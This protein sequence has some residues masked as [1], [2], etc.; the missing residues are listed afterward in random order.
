MG[1]VH[2]FLVSC[3]TRQGET[4]AVTGNTNVLGNW[5]K[6]GIQFM[7][8]D[9][10]DSNV[11]RLAVT[12]PDDDVPEYRYCVVVV[13]RPLVRG[14]PQHVI[15][16]RWET[17]ILPRRAHSQEGDPALEEFGVVDKVRRI[18]R[19][20]LTEEVVVQ[21]KLTG[22]A[23][24][25]W[26]K[27]Y[28]K[29]RL[30]VKVTPLVKESGY[31]RDSEN[32]L[33]ESI[34]LHE[35]RANHTRNWP[36]V[37][38]ASLTGDQNEKKVQ[39]Q[40][41]ISYSNSR[42]AFVLFEAQ[43]RLP[44]TVAFLVD[45]YGHGVLSSDHD[46]PDHLGIGY[47]YP[48]NLKQ[49]Q[50]KL[51]TPIISMKHQPIGKIHVDYLMIR[52]MV[53]TECDFSVSYSK[54]WNEMWDGLDVGHRG[55][56][57]SH[58]KAQSCS[59]TRENTIAS[60]KDALAHGA[61]MVEFDVQVSKDLVPVVYHEFN[62]C[63]KTR[64]KRGEDLTLEIPVKDLTVEELQRLKILHPTEK[65]E[66]EKQF[67]NHDDDDHQA[68][69]TLEHTLETLDTHLGFNIE[70][71]IGNQF[72]DGSEEEKHPMEMN[73]FVDQIIKT[74]LLHGGQRNIVFS[75]FHP[76]ACTMLRTKQNK[77]P[78]LLLTQGKSG[79]YTE[80][81]DPRTWNIPNA[82]WFVETADILGISVIAEEFMCDPNQ[83]KLL[84]SRGQVIFCWT[85]DKND[86]ETVKYLKDLGINGIIYDRMDQNNFKD[87]KQSIFLMEGAGRN[88]AV[89]DSGNSGCSSGGSS[90]AYS[91]YN[92]SSPR[93]NDDDKLNFKG[94][95]S[96][97]VT[98]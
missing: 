70:I 47:I 61:D 75:S 85:D 59:N 60:M 25:I 18:Q 23:L 80:Y 63:V 66:G 28:D 96:N 37:E 58:T 78:V 8:R 32:N 52:P 90:P 24:T 40:F 41:G 45:I 91:D 19:G 39:D 55:L 7:T 11:W 88:R 22:N 94:F 95:F 1:R 13:L 30:K 51:Q 2:T 57:N 86:R 74:V 21:L 46:I 48:E 17:H 4:L 44:H 26:R 16:R 87:V 15:V 73:L 79:K 10:S 65:S 72:H 82:S 12:L 69:P 3:H 27:K 84:K 35:V 71:K 6:D 50:G 53:G 31:D 67:P 14:D 42:D 62:I 34:D 49:T 92:K 56:G 83:V 64:Q 54:Y 89:S 98:N 43:L 76:D 97:N 33:E 68:F 9:D 20:W 93:R 5:R 77:Y 36:I 38:A 81:I 29:H